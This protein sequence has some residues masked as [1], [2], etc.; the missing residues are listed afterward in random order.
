MLK[1]YFLVIS[2]I[3]QLT[4]AKDERRFSEGLAKDKSQCGSH[5]RWRKLVACEQ[6][7]IPRWRKLVACA[8]F[9]IQNSKFIIV[10]SKFPTKH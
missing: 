1:F 8:Q 6:F 9:K 5:P 10:N 3:H 7:K 4:T 2:L